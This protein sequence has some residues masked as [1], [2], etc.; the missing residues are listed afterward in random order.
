MRAACVVSFAVILVVSG[1]AIPPS[2]LFR[3]RSRRAFVWGRVGG[4]GC[5]VIPTYDWFT[6]LVRSI[7]LLY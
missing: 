3:W 7:S 2:L 6:S 4:Y 5:R 1:G